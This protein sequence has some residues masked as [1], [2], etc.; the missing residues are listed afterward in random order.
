[1]AAV[2]M[3]T[4]AEIEEEQIGTLLVRVGAAEGEHGAG[5]WFKG[6]QSKIY[7]RLSREGDTP[8]L[9]TLSKTVSLL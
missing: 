9:K 5:V 1:M 3:Q 4:N 6:V 8:V 2:S 7:K